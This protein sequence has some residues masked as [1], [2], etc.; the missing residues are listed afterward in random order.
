MAVDFVNTINTDIIRPMKR[1]FFVFLLIGTLACQPHLMWWRQEP[2]SYQSMLRKWTRSGQAYQGMKTLAVINAAFLHPETRQAYVRQYAKDHRLCEE[3]KAD[4]LSQQEAEAS[5]QLEF[6][7]TI[8]SDEDDWSRLE[9]DSPIWSIYFSGE[10]CDRVK[11][12]S[13][14]YLKDVPIYIR[15]H[16]PFDT[17][18]TKVY[19]VI[20]PAKNQ[21]Q[22][23]LDEQTRQ[24]KLE[25]LSAVTQFEMEWE[26]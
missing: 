18:L 6:I 9:G 2:D 26:L 16:F 4:L 22:P 10:K 23:L 5:R 24:F 3:E 12:Q 20:F 1:L 17:D 7:V 25:F 8:L 11:P 13:I 21:N 19:R 14:E 15:R